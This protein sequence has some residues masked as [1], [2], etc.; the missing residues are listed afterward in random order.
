MDSGNMRHAMRTRGRE[1]HSDS[2]R[3]RG[4]NF[5]TYKKS[6]PAILGH[7]FAGLALPLAVG[8]VHAADL[9]TIQV[10][11]TTIDDRFEAK[12][13]EASNIAVISGERVDTSRAENIQQLL[14]SVPGITTEFD[15]QDH[16]KIH[17]RGV[18]NQ[19][20][21]GEKPGVA[22]VID[23]VP[24]FERTGK[25][26][27]DLDNIESIKVIKG[28]ASYL[29]G[30]DALAGAVIITTKRGAKNAG[31]RVSADRG[32]DGY[33]KGLFRAGYANDLFNT[34][35]QV[36]RRASDGYWFQSDYTADYVNG[37]LQYYLDDRSDITF[38]FERAE[39]AKDSH[40]SVEGATQA[41]LDPRSVEG[42][43]YAR[44]FDVSLGKYFAT[45]ARDFGETSN[46]LV[47]VYQFAD[48]TS[49]VSAPQNFDVDGNR[50]TDV[51][52][53]TNGNDY[54]QVQRGIKSEWRSGGERFAWM[55]GLDL[56][57]NT[58]ENKTRYLVDHKTSPSPFAPVR[59]AGTV[60]QDNTTD[61]NVQAL[62][63]ELKF[64]LAQPLTV[65]LNG[66][67]DKIELD[68][69]DKLNDLTLG[70]TFSVS[71]WRL[72]G[73][74]ALSDYNDLYANISTGFRAP[75]VEQ[76][77]AGDISPTGDTASNPNLKPEQA[78][79]KEIGLRSKTELF[80][81]PWDLD[82]AIFRI[83]RDDYIM[84]SVGQYGGVPAGE[85]Q[86]FQNIGG[87]RSQGLELALRSDPSRKWWT[88]IAYT[89]LDAKFTDY[90]NFNLLLGNRYGGYFDS[91]TE[92][93]ADGICAPGEYDPA[94][95]Y[96]IERRDNTGNVV[97]RVPRHHLNVALNYRATPR[98]TLTGEM[99]AISSYYADEVN[100][101]NIGG[102]ATF[103]LMTQYD[104]KF[105]NNQT[106]SFFA[107]IDN[108]FDRRFYN[109]ARGNYDSASIG[110]G[111]VPDGRLTDED[112]SIV[113]NPGRTFTLGIEAVF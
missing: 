101:V 80:G 113:V 59:R 79:N 56:R 70:K 69:K 102:H 58:Y 73:N 62:Y 78:I 36:S 67:Y 77:F 39:R 85:Q 107:R 93:N 53:Y 33:Y 35:L 66:R 52:A 47:N 60:T 94:R 75:T 17:M 111:G 90:K 100:L 74:Y 41:R 89:Y 48:D 97:P 13:S 25:V 55:A 45:Y 110:T 28:G 82:L 8:I 27:I 61:E 91:T 21:Y 92:G 57:A 20:Y 63:G 83:D 103:N 86:Q 88:S 2:K 11:S 12:R 38:G 16:L 98:W 23:G 64:S 99:D 42:R 37:K 14:Q 22:I 29:F 104:L 105:G 19:R 49:F 46:L 15:S 44:K 87:M 5:M 18:E 9:G 106:W 51:D 109:T 71:S 95:N 68:Y 72:G 76:L 26:N 3:S 96:C 84:A 81:I 65:T 54:H 108:L 10:E 31:F 34:H 6:L 50:V 43:D 4:G 24:V 112:I 30:D 40:G 1:K 7:V 32:S